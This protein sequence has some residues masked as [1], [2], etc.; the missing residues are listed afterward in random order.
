M[1]DGGILNASLI[2]DYFGSVGFEMW[3]GTHLDVFDASI[4]VADGFFIP[5]HLVSLRQVLNAAGVEVAKW[6]D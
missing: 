2:P 1:P 4:G 5:P 6:R 3:K